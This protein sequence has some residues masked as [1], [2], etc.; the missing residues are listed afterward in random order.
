LGAVL[1]VFAAQSGLD[2][3][4]FMTFGP[5]GNLYVSSPDTDRVLKY[6]GTTG[7]FLGNSVPP[8]SGGLDAPTG[9]VNATDYTLCAEP[10]GSPYINVTDSSGL[11]AGASMSIVLEFQNPS[12]QGITYATRVLAGTEAR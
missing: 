12:N 10:D 3:A 2:R 5:D 9:L 1:D 6:D 4:A 7:A 11:A 8:G